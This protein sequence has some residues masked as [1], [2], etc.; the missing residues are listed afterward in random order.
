MTPPT[1]P[2]PFRFMD[3]PKEL[4]LMVHDHLPRQIKHTRI[5][6]HGST[7][8]LIT[9]H[10]PLAILRTSREIHA[11]ASAIVQKLV[12][13]FIVKNPPKK[14]HQLRGRCCSLRNLLQ[15]IV[16]GYVYAQASQAFEIKILHHCT[17]QNGGLH[18]VRPEE[19]SFLRQAVESGRGNVDRIEL[20]TVRHI[21]DYRNGLQGH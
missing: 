18:Y 21:S 7:F 16:E 20:E 14:F 15:G 8:V 17:S 11:E 5:T 2:A 9:R 10:L 19:R 13:E 6:E 1:Q 4:R 3:L 12:K